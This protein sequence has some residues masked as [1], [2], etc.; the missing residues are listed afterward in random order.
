MGIV[1]MITG[2][3]SGMHNLQDVLIEELK[4]L[5]NAENQLVKA[6]PKMEKRASS[7]KLKQALKSHLEETKLQ[8]ERLKT[9]GQELGVSLSGKTCKAMQGLV[10]EGEEVMEEESDNPALIDALLIG[11]A[12]RVEHYEIAAYGTARAMAQ[13][14]GESKVVKLLDATIKEEGAADKK[15]TQISEGE[16]LPSAFKATKQAKASSEKGAANGKSAGKR[17]G[18]TGRPGKGSSRGRSRKGSAAERSR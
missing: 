7:P 2:S 16:V 13:Q 1:E 18:P 9:A 14:L 17:S 10:E 5:F 11:A 8:V 12:Q 3:S 6:L 15:L 4:D